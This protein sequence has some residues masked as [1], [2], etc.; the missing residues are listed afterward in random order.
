[1]PLNIAKMSDYFFSNYEG[2]TM[3]FSRKQAGELLGDLDEAERQLADYYNNADYNFQIIEGILSPVPINNIRVNY[4]Q[5]SSSFTMSIRREP[6]VQLYGYA[7]EP[8]G[9]VPYGTGFSGTSAS[10][11]YAW[12]HRLSMSGV[13]TYYTINWMETVRLLIAI[14]NNEQKSPQSHSTLNRVYLPKVVV[15]EKT[16][17]VKALVY[18]SQVYKLGVGEVTASSIAKKF[19]SL[20]DIM[21]AEVSELTACDG[22][23]K[24]TASKLLTALGRR[25]V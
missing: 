13:Y 6:L 4:P 7:V 8:S 24:V 11:L 16:P 3:Q 22:V 21:I 17:L 10:M 23:G 20:S 1:M 9:Q 12:V 25:D 2:R 19:S 14:H 15:T 5:G 18:L